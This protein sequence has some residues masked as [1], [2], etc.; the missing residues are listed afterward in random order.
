MNSIAEK[1]YRLI[2]ERSLGTDISSLKQRGVKRVS[3]FKANQLGSLVGMAVEQ[4]LRDYGIKLSQG[5]LDSLSEEGRQAFMNLLQERDS[6]KDI[7]QNLEKEQDT[8][9]LQRD[10]LKGQIRR[11]DTLIETEKGFWQE[12]PLGEDAHGYQDRLREVL[13]R[14][15]E[16]RIEALGQS[17]DARLVKFLE[18]MVEGLLREL[19]ELFS[20]SLDE[21]Q[22][23][24]VDEGQKRINTLERRVQKMRESLD[25]AEEALERAQSQAV[26]DDGVASIYRNVQGLR[27]DD[28]A[29]GQKKN[30]LEEIFQLN[31]NIKDQI[32]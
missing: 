28:E 23:R 12:I 15:L 7:C 31:K 3:V 22:Q 11:E 21:I 4:V 24:Y 25:S 16:T 17:P 18:Q 1:I 13:D 19:D 2:R 29:Y 32:S 14:T 6:Y 27:T 5:D 26:A 9:A 20:T 8:L 10:M 30:M